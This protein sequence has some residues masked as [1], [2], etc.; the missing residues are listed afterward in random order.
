MENTQG[1]FYS[2]QFDEWKKWY[3]ELT[4][5]QIGVLMYIKL[6]DS[7]G[8]GARIKA[9]KIAEELKITKRAVNS[10]IEVLASKGLLPDWYKNYLTSKN[11]IEM[12][13][14]D[15]MKEE[16]GGAVEVVTAVGRIDLLTTTEIIEI[17][18]IND[19]K[20]ALGKLLAYSSF[21][22]EHN[23]RIHLFGRLDLSKL[24][25]A[26]ATCKEFDI[27]VTFEEA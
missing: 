25:T 21:F 3:I 12:T 23:K 1:N 19:W 5:S 11:N 16:L 8:N 6:A 27:T 22:P 15:R 18:E 9:S 26:Q 20:E 24:A 13:I 10:A 4:K 7:Y 2:I 17:K 14:R